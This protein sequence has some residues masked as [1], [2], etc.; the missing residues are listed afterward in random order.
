RNFQY[1]PEERQGLIRRLAD[2]FWGPD[3]TTTPH[4][5]APLHG[6]TDRLRLILISAIQV[7]KAVLFS[8][9]ITVAAFVPLFTMQGAEGAIF[10]PMA[11]TYGYA[12]AGGLLATFT[13]TPALASFLIPEHVHEAET[14]FVR[15]LRAA[16]TPV[17]HWSLGHRKSMLAIGLGFLAVIGL[18]GTQLGGEF[19]PHL[20]EGNF[21]IRITLPPSTGL[22]SGTPATAKF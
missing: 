17:L 8:A 16:Y 15:A 12:L 9:L 1:D 2:G 13:V 21:W 22:A 3:P 10:G 19:L 18:L 5:A 6:W 20:E 7:D 11:R 14:I 4:Q